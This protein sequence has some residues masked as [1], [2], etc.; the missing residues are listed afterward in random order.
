MLEGIDAAA[1]F[2]MGPIKINCVVQR[3]V[4]EGEIVPLARHFRGS[5]HILRFIEFMDVGTRNH[6]ELAKVVSAREI[7]ARIDAEFPIEPIEP[8]YA[9]EVARRWRYADGAG[10]IGVITSVTN[11]FCSG[12]T[13]ARLTADGQLVTCL[14]A[15]TGLDLKGPLRKGESDAEILERIRAAWGVRRDRYSEERASIGKV[16]P[17]ERIEMYRVGG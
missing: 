14:F 15:S 16:A 1:A 12:C 6:W 11:P 7:V 3:G 2:G 13:R 5:G 9:G 17:R 10:E 4:N 8:N